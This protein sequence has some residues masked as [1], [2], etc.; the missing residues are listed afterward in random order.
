MKRQGLLIGSFGIGALLGTPVLR[1]I[2]TWSGWQGAL[3]AYGGFALA[4]T[5]V[6]ASVL[7]D[8]PAERSE[9]EALATRLGAAIRAT[10]RPMI[11]PALMTK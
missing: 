9:R 4:V 11:A 5:F 2:A 1:W 10:R 7:P 3:I 6:A 8:F